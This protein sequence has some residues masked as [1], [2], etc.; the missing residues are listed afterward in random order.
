MSIDKMYKYNKNRNNIP[1]IY[2]PNIYFQNFHRKINFED[3]FGY[4]QTFQRKNSSD[5]YNLSLSYLRNNIDNTLILEKK[6][7]LINIIH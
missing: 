1:L 7:N 4:N 5:L 2:K 3:A 6:L